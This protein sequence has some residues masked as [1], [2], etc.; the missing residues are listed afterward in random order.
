MD[1]LIYYLSHT[2]FN[3]FDNIAQA[4]YNNGGVGFNLD[5]KKWVLEISY[6][7]N[8]NEFTYIKYDIA[9]DNNLQLRLKMKNKRIKKF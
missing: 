5:K 6:N 2:V 3:N 1:D 7:S 9:H 8:P 4:L